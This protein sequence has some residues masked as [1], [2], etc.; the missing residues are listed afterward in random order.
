MWTHPGRTLWCTG[1][2][3]VGDLLGAAPRPGP[4]GALA[5]LIG[6]SRAALVR[7]LAVPATTTQLAATLELS[8]G[9]VG[10]HLAVLRG[11]GLVRRVR[12]GRAV[13]Y[14]RTALGDALADPL[15]DAG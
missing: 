10:D 7:A 6:G 11:A 14:R 9:T 4:A 2:R 3:G 13:Q 5:R 15:P 8:L 12:V 1:P